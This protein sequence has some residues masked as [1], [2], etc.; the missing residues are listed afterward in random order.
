MKL[1][2]VVE[3][4]GM[5]CA[6][7]AGIL[8][9]FLDEGY[10]FDYAIGVSAGSSSTASFL[11]GQKDRNR[12]FFVDHV[13]EPGYMGFRNFLKTGSFFGLEYIY[14]EL[15][16][17][18]GADPIDYRALMDN[19][20]EFE[21]VATN[22]K[23]GRAHYFNK[24]DAPQDDY[25]IFMASCA[26]PVASRPVKIDGKIYYDGG[27]SDPIPVQRALDKGCDKVVVLLCRPKDTI[28]TPEKHQEIEKLALLKYPKTFRAVQ[29]R[30]LVYNE[31]LSWIRK[32]EQEG[33]ALII[34]PKEAL[35]V[36]TYTRDPEVL[37]NLYNI[38][39][40]DFPGIKDRLEAFMAGTE[41]P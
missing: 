35:P 7:T 34:A 20:T 6:Y 32:L 29:N 22:A 31:T 39:L 16:N 33:K 11:A 37:Q 10:T 5:K 36:S 15:T 27:C 38:A 1:G 13:K 28:R 8:D 30:Y 2:L 17:S 14:A 40:K 3:G 21:I 9:R 41:R 4:G 12:R 19:P 18:D 25:R 24:K 23:T 26:I